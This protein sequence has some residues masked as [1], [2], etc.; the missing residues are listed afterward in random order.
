MG[1]VFFCQSCGAR[2]KVDARMAGKKGRCTRCHQLVAIPRAEELSSVLAMPVPSAAAVAQPSASSMESWL[3]TASSN[4]GL[5]PLSVDRIPIA[6]KRG[7]GPTPLDDAEDSKPYA[8]TKPTVAER[9]RSSGGPAGLIVTIWRRD[10]GAIQRVFRWLNESAY[11]VSIPFLMILFAGVV[12]RN[13]PLALFGAT[14]VVVLN[15]GRFAAG[16]FNLVFVPLRDGL[17]VKKLKKPIRR[18]VE[19]VLTVG[20]V[21]LAFTFIP[22]LSTGASRSGSVADRLR[23]SAPALEQEIKGELKTVVEK[24]RTLDVKQLEEQA[25]EK[26]K[27]FG[28]GGTDGAPDEKKV[29]SGPP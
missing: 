4:V 16:V 22:W 23:T 28:E 5:A 20:A 7:S 3:K 12:L 27:G 25:K 26:L 10:I 14:F 13:R 17:N 29:G 18:I 6:P 11:L 2:F 8:L 21:V 19:P 15:L 1:I 24:A 9:Y